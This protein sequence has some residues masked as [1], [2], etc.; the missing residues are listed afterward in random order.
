MFRSNTTVRLISWMTE[1]AR[2]SSSFMKSSRGE[3]IG[4]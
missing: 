1:M 4:G 3:N 2:F